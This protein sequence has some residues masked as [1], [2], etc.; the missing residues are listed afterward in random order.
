MNSILFLCVLVSILISCSAFSMTRSAYLTP[1]TST[2]PVLQ[3]GLGDMFKGAFEN[4]AMP[5]PVNAGLSKDPVPVTVKFLPSGKE[6]Q[7][8]PGQKLS[9]VA[10][11]ARVRIKYNCNEGDFVSRQIRCRRSPN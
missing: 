11:A 5:P 9:L 4:Q 7:A 8:F 3:M 6:C 1:R 10:N 2:S